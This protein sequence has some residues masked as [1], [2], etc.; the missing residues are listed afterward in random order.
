MPAIPRQFLPG[1]VAARL[2]G[3]IRRGRWSGPF[4]G[5]PRVAG[6]TRSGAPCGFQWLDLPHLPRSRHGPGGAEGLSPRRDQQKR[7]ANIPNPDRPAPDGHLSAAARQFHPAASSSGPTPPRQSSAASVTNFVV[8]L[9]VNF[10]E[11]AGDQDYDKAYC[12]PLSFR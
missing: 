10:I 11:K 7:H 2:R 9:V 5:L 12:S 4:P 8:N 6:V 3:G 1:K